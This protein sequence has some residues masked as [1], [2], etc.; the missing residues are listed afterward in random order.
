MDRRRFTL[1]G[2]VNQ[3]NIRPEPEVKKEETGESFEKQ[4]AILEL[5]KRIDSV[6]ESIARLNLDLARTSK[7]FDALFYSLPP[8]EQRVI[9]ERLKIEDNVASGRDSIG[10]IAGKKKGRHPDR[11]TPIGF[12][13]KN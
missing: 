12:V 10:F 7:E 3:E 5:L 2:D 8:E 13:K 1:E 6:A 4:G 11:P 9:K